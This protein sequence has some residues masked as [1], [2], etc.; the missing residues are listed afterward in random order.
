MRRASSEVVSTLCDYLAKSGSLSKLTL[1][2]S[3]LFANQECV[4]HLSKYFERVSQIDR[5]SMTEAYLTHIELSDLNLSGKHL[6]QIMKALRYCST[7]QFFSL[8]GNPISEESPDFNRYL[9]KM[10]SEN[11]KYLT[12]LNLSGM[13]ILKFDKILQTV[14]K[15]SQSL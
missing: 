8:K 1:S 4:D 9:Q 2:D 10:L 5:T 7:L 6:T 11:N 3:Q 13:K 12:H 14:M 15:N